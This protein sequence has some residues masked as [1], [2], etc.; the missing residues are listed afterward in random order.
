MTDNE[1]TLVPYLRTL[2]GRAEPRFYDQQDKRQFEAGF[3]YLTEVLPVGGILDRRIAAIEKAI[4]ENDA[5]VAAAQCEERAAKLRRGNAIRLGGDL[6]S[7]LHRTRVAR[8]A[9]D[10]V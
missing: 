7:L 5:K 8:K 6:R 9:V 3:D 1:V 2:L 4:E 10:D